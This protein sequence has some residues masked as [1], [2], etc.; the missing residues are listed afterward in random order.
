MKKNK[1]LIKRL[2]EKK[3]T[4]AS[5]E[6]YTGGMFASS[7][8]DVPGASIVFL[9]GVVS[10]SIFSKEKILNVK[11]ETID[12]FDVVSKEVAKEMAKNIKNILNSDIAISFTGNAGPT[13]DGSKKKNIGEVYIYIIY[14]EKEI[15]YHLFLKGKRNKVRNDSVKFAINELLKII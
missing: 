5:S 1:L 6:S 8:V 9:G 14:K 12:E 15:S 2:K 7:L 13:T 10:Y 4:I 11:K 3:L